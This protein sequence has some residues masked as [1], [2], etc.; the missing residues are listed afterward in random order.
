MSENGAFSLTDLLR[1]V[2]EVW[3]VGAEGDDRLRAFRAHNG[4]AV[5]T[6]PQVALHGLRHFAPIVQRQSICSSPW[7][8]PDLRFSRVIAGI[9]LSQ[10]ERASNKN[11]GSLYG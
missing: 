1:P 8:R 7:R 6:A 11:T 10:G 2:P 4:E 9:L 3:I 5:L